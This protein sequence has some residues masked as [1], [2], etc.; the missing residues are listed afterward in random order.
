M[1]KRKSNRALKFDV[2]KNV[3]YGYITKRKKKVLEFEGSTV[4]SFK[5]IEFQRY[6]GNNLPPGRYYFY[7]KFKND[8]EPYTGNTNTAGVIEKMDNTENE[9]ILKKFDEV[10]KKINSKTDGISTDLL[11]SVT[12][13]SYE[14]HINFLNTQVTKLEAELRDLSSECE[15]LTNDCLEYEQEIHKLKNK[16]EYLPLAEKALILLQAKFGTG[17]VATLENSDPTDIPQEILQILGTV[18]YIKL[19]ADQAAYQKIV[20]GLRQ[21][22]SLLP[23]KV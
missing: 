15:S 7:I 18:D 1:A 4:E 13:Q 10:L 14:T 12:K 23:Q 20:S 22:I 16:S 11:L 21:Y 19:Q 8:P 2:L 9:V 3:D 17:K 5:W 6:L